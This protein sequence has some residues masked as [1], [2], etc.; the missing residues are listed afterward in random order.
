MC[1]ALSRAKKEQVVAAL[2]D[3]FNTAR[4]VV[5]V[6]F[7]GMTAQE[8]GD[9]R[10]ACAEEEVS[11]VVA[12]KTLIRKVFEDVVGGDFPE[13]EREIALVYGADVLAPARVV[14]EQG[15]NLGDHLRIIGGVFDG[16]LV[17]EERM[18]AIA[19]IPPLAV[20]HAQF[21]MVINSPLQGLVSVLDQIAGVTDNK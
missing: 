18:Q 10:D 7:C 3:V 20:L 13:V 1:M 14:G 6:E 12:K 19:D 17:S 15:K 9:F 5:F 4:T 21:L 11:C 8:S 16:V 2:T